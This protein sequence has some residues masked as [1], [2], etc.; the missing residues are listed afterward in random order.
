[1][2]PI[3]QIAVASYGE[4]ITCV[5]VEQDSQR[6]QVWPGRLAQVLRETSVCR[7]GAEELYEH[8]QAASAGAQGCHRPERVT[9]ADAVVL[10]GEELRLTHQSV[11]GPNNQSV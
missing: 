1:M 11:K 6:R 8:V 2:D 5:E 3:L 7:P 10:G 4:A 9:L